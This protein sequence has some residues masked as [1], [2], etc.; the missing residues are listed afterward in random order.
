[1]ITIVIA[2]I[3]F[4]LI[5]QSELPT[6]PN[7]SISSPFPDSVIVLEDPVIVRGS[8]SDPNGIASIEFWVNGTLIGEQ[9]N[10]DP[11]PDEEF[12]ASQ[13]FRPSEIGSYTIFLRAADAEGYSNES[14]PLVLEAV[15]YEPPGVM[16]IEVLADEDDTLESL[17]EEYGT[18]PGELD[19]LNPGGITPGSLVTVRVPAGQSAPEGDEE[20]DDTVPPVG[21]QPP[22]QT[23]GSGGSTL[24]PISLPGWVS[25]IP[26]SVDPSL[27]CKIAPGICNL[28]STG[29]IAPVVPPVPQVDSNSSSCEVRLAWVDDNE[30]EAGFRIYR[31]NLSSGIQI[32]V[33][34]LGDL[35]GSGQTAV[36]VDT[37]VDTG[38]YRYLISA[39]N[40]GGES[41]SGASEIV[42]VDCPLELANASAVEIGMAEM[43]TAQ[44]YD[45]LYCYMSFMGQ[46]YQRFPAGQNNFI[47]PGDEAID[48]AA[49]FGFDGSRRLVL[50]S[51]E[52]LTF[53][54]ECWGWQGGNLSNLGSF[55]RSHPPEDW[56]GQVYAA[57]PDTGTY[58]LAYR[59]QGLANNQTR[60]GHLE[61]FLIPV[62]TNLRAVEFRHECSDTRGCYSIVEPS[63][64]WDYD[65]SIELP[66]GQSLAGFYV[67]R[68]LPSETRDRLFFENLPYLEEYNPYVNNTAPLMGNCESTATYY[69]TTVS[70]GVYGEI[71]SPPSEDFHY[72]TPC[73]IALEI[74]METLETGNLKDGVLN[75]KLEAYGFLSFL[76]KSGET[77]DHGYTVEWNG[78]PNIPMGTWC[79]DCYGDPEPELYIAP[80]PYTTVLEQDRTYHWEDFWLGIDQYENGEGYY[81]FNRNPEADFGKNQ[82]VYIIPF[83]N[84]LE[85]LRIWILVQ[86][87]DGRSGDD[88]WCDRDILYLSRSPEEWLALDEIVSVS[89][90]EDH[91]EGTITL[92]IRGVEYE[93]DE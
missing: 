16:D 62:P 68:R 69:V 2:V 21:T 42:E 40:A 24:T 18:D 73:Q 86:E 89:C 66:E 84:E 34:E 93:G 71:E 72:N 36:Y 10:P 56:N 63:L 28:R 52:P 70:R 19:E 64:M 29:G 47:Q 51:E 82:N 75:N 17:A 53:E 83:R 12:L 87:D 14:V 30:D 91:G 15:T 79:K 74:T 31:K 7:V 54:G 90:D 49:F 37:P 76:L 20:Q 23:P 61:S 58:A 22:G 11:Q 1:L 32:E 57:G 77:E 25:V 78:H 46:P 45:R 41:F 59:L 88:Q 33:E 65:D 81:F 80:P 38:Q 50:P 67:Y 55:I 5:T 92:R 43:S 35:D 48:L 27:I 6:L 9:V 8:A 85:S 3:F 26:A 60:S 39:F 13:S 4:L 44:Q